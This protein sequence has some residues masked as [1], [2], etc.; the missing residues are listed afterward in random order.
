MDF[1]NPF[2][3]HEEE[4]YI[5]GVFHRLITKTVLSIAYHDRI[6]KG[7]IERIKK[8]YGKFIEPIF[9]PTY[10]GLERNV[11]IFSAAKQYQQVREMTKFIETDGV[12]STF[13]DFKKK[14]ATVFDTYNKNYL[15]A[16]YDTA[17]G[18]SQM[19][20]EWVEAVQKADIFPMLTYQT[21]RDLRVREVHRILDG[22]T[23]PVNH[24]FWNLNMPKNGWNCRCFTTSNDD[25]ATDLKTIDLSA[26]KDEK[27]FPPLFRMN[28]G[29]DKVI[30]DP[31][32]HP[33]FKVAKGDEQLKK[34]NFKLPI[35]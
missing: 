11:Y 30:F 14:A 13:T 34:E 32:R 2:D 18:Q 29:K 20:R 28:P 7:F 5:T 23:L 22:I 27:K 35:P 6:T 15:K 9:R 26:L 8:G 1:E 4:L 17:I 24:P 21:Q 16:E 25:K 33:Y 12:T 19:A 3:P 31:K 10:K